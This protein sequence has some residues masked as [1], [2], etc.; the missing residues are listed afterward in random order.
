M[1][2]DSA[3]LFVDERKLDQNVVNHL[4]DV[5]VHQYDSV[6][7]WLTK[8]HSDAKKASNDHKVWI[9]ST[10]NY[11]WGNVIGEEYSLVAVSPISGFKAIKNQAELQGMRNSHVSKLFKEGFHIRR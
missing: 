9:T 2:N 11:A 5:K 8:F 1:T 3:H 6:I 4:G 10:T 7:N